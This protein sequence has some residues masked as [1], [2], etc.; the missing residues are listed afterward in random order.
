MD[1]EPEKLPKQLLDTHV[2]VTDRE[3]H[4]STLGYDSQSTARTLAVLPVVRSLMDQAG[5]IR[6]ES[7]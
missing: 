4:N 2:L 5:I 7:R 6:Y 1:I 3:V